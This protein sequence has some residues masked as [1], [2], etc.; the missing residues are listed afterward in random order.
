MK[1]RIFIILLAVLSLL[2]TSCKMVRSSEW[3]G[4]S[5]LDLGNMGKANR[6]CEKLLRALEKGD[7]DT[8][9]EMF[10]ERTVKESE[11]FDRNLDE[12]FEY[13]TGELVTEELRWHPCN[14]SHNCDSEGWYDNYAGTADIETSDGVYRFAIKEYLKHEGG[15]DLEGIS[16]LY[17]IRGEDDNYFPEVKYWGDGK[18]TPGIHIGIPQPRLSKELEDSLYP[19]ESDRT[20]RPWVTD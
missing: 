6:T 2:F 14:N 18:D 8:V 1:K 19:N 7:R 10:S 13:F 20:M 9:R 5:R 15:R 4:N 17:V 3:L 11:N 12:L 16:S